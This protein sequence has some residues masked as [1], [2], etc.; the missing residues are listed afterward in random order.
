MDVPEMP[1]ARLPLATPV[2]KMLTPGAVTF[3]LSQLSPV[4]GPPDVKLASPEK[5]V[6]ET[7]VLFTVVVEPDAAR[8]LAPSEVGVVARP[9]TPM[10]GIVTVKGSPVSG[11]EKIGP[12]N[13]GKEVE[14]LTIATAA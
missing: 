8:S 11:F 14:L 13:G 12:S 10:N 4:L 6:L 3:G 2:E 5:F 7:V 9:R 1:A